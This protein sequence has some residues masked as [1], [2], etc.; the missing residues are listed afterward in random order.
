MQ[1]TFGMVVG[2]LERVIVELCRQANPDRYRLSVCCLGVRGPLADLVEEAG[3]P[4]TVCTD[5]S[6]RGKYLR[7]FELAR[8]LAQQRVDIVHAHHTPALVDSAVAAVMGRVPL[9]ATDHCKAYPTSFRWRLLERAASS[10]ASAIVVVSDQSGRDLVRHQGIRADKVVTIHNGVEVVRK[11]NVSREVLRGELGVALDDVVVV[12]AARLEP[13]KG[14]CLLID[15]APDVLRYQPKTKFLVIGGGTE[16]QALRERARRLGVDKSVIFT[17]YRLDAVDLMAA[18]DCFVQTS[19]WEGLPM[20]LLEA[21]A[22]RLP[23]VATSVGGVPEVVEHGVTGLLLSDRD[24]LQLSRLLLEVT[25]DPEKST[26]MGEAGHARYRSRFSAE[27]M[28]AQYEKLYERVLL[29][30]P[31]RRVQ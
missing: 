13:Q 25:R 31:T 30:A 10:A 11:R 6:R 26:Q 1:V 4:V 22:L 2:G 5:Q 24:P 27:A 14:L 28:M 21:M 9:V 3:V 18:S 12:T 15:S 19:Y 23:V 17:D 20:T 29:Q 16:L 8:I 7:G